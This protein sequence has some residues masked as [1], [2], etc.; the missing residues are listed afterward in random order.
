MTSPPARR[1]PLLL[2]LLA[3]LLAACGDDRAN[4]NTSADASTDAPDLPDDL[5]D[6][7]SDDNSDALP[8]MTEDAYTPPVLEDGVVL[9][10]VSVPG[11]AAP[12]NPVSGAATPPEA[13]MARFVRYTL[14]EPGPLEEREGVLVMVPGFLAGAG[15]FD[16]LARQVVQ[17]TQGRFEVWAVDRR[18]NGLEDHRGMEAAVAALDPEL[19]QG[20][21][22][23]GALID[24]ERFAGLQAPAALDF[25]SEW[26]LEVHLGDLRAILALV[27]PALRERHLFLGGH[28]LGA[29]LVQAYASFT[30]EDGHQGHDD[31]AGL[32]LYD[33]AV[34]A[35]G[36]PPTQAEFLEG[37]QGFMGRAPGL[38]GCARG[39]TWS[40]RCPSCRARCS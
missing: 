19:A 14:G 11:F 28:S 4:N 10:A 36:E 37:Y 8:D 2:L 39:E 6:P 29:S 20:Y 3:L 22:F 17:R 31:I 35:G 18:S 27:P 30:F 25:A 23:D 26:G 38:N 12:P 9:T 24:G 40:R 7:D 33:G 34:G 32:I 5:T 15:S 21:Y 13:S 16:A 1:S